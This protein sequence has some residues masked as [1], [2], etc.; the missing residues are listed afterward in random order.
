M[1]KNDNFIENWEKTRKVGKFKYIFSNNKY[2][3]ISF[4]A[5]VVISLIFT[6]VI[7]IYTGTDILNVEIIKKTAFRIFYIIA[8]FIIYFYIKWNNNEKKYN[9][10]TN[11]KEK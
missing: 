10:L 3:F 7:S 9:K 4:F 6:L 1:N 11:N 8:V 2:F 5:V